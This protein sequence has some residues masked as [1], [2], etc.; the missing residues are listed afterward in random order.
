MKRSQ[1]PP[2]KNLKQ[3]STQ[4]NKA[5]AWIIDRTPGKR[6]DPPMPSTSLTGIQ[7][8]CY[9]KWLKCWHIVQNENEQKKA[10]CKLGMRDD[11]FVP[12]DWPQW[13][14]ERR[15]RR[16][17]M[18]TSSFLQYISLCVVKSFFFLTSMETYHHISI[19]STIHL[20]FS[21]PTSA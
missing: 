10:E 12:D 14:P 18:W 3:T 7:K 2:P 1:S 8:H 19:I 9:E 6:P 16:D 20:Y 17:Y 5:V 11:E 15:K 4:I 21:L 13:T